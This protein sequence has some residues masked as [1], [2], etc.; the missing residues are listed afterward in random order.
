MKMTDKGFCEAKSCSSHAIL[1]FIPI[2]IKMEDF[3]IATYKTM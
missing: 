1:T 3:M 2:F